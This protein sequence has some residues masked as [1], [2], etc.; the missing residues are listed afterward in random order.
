MGIGFWIGRFVTVFGICC[1]ILF[2]VRM[3]RGYNLEDSAT[4]AML[5]GAITAV[6]FVGARL[7][8][9]RRKMHCAICR[10]TPEMRDGGTSVT[11][12][13]GR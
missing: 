5:W 9:S 4:Y 8:Q 6:V 7:Y 1:A 13:A 12:P 3:L 11:R 10:D 2:G